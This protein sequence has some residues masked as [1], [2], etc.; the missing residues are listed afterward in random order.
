MKKITILIT[1]LV[2]SITVSAQTW[3]TK[4][5]THKYDVN[6]SQVNDQ[7]FF[8]TSWVKCMENFHTVC[9]NTW[10]CTPGVE[11]LLV[12]LAAI[13]CRANT[14]TDWFGNILLTREQ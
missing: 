3:E 5:L 11:A 4:E 1:V 13:Q 2:L 8:K 10:W 9:M 12:P 14:E 7:T 6:Y